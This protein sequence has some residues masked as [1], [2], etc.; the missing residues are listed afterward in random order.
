MHSLINVS[1]LSEI[2]RKS[3]LNTFSQ[4][5]HLQ[6]HFTPKPFTAIPNL[7]SLSR[8]KTAQPLVGKGKRRRVKY[9]YR[10]L[11]IQLKKLGIFN[12]LDVINKY[13]SFLFLTL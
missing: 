4:F 6:A 7:K 10:K 3:K 12:R 9:I 2:N 13:K 5:N 11:K 8:V 1:L